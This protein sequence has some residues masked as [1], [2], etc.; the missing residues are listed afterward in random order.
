M[1]IQQE[2]LYPLTFII[3]GLLGLEYTIYKIIEWTSGG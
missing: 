1:K 3:S 2:D